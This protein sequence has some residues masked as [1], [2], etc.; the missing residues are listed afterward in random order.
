[1]RTDLAESGV[2]LE[3]AGIDPRVKKFCGGGGGGR[4]TSRYITIGLP[5]QPKLHGIKNQDA[6]VENQI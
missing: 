1:M 6:L 4:R 5:S 3:K 2:V